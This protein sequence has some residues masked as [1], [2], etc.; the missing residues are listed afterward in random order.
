VDPG[1]LTGE[2]DWLGP[3]GRV[4]SERVAAL[5]EVTERLDPL[6]LSLPSDFGTYFTSEGLVAALHARTSCA[7]DLFGP[8]PSPVEAEAHLIRYFRDQQDCVEWYIYL[9][10]G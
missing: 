1:R 9:R 3:R 8:I 5:R 7:G 10:P 4:A 6:G 2:F